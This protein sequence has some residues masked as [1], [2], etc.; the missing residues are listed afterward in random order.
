VSVT[1]NIYQEIKDATSPQDAMQ[2]YI[3]I[4]DARPE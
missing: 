3:Q 2:K 4:I 1:Q